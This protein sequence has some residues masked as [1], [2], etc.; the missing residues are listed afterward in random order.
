MALV[1]EIARLLQ[2]AGM[3]VGLL[4]EALDVDFAAVKVHFLAVLCR[5]VSAGA[6]RRG[7]RGLPADVLNLSLRELVSVEPRGSSVV[8]TT[9]PVAR[10]FGGR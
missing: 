9:M 10:A 2:L 6:A 7:L 4:D 5:G 8:V 1:G 3:P